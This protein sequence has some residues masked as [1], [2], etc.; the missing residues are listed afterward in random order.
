MLLISILVVSLS[1]SWAQGNTSAYDLNGDYWNILKEEEK[2]ILVL[3][4]IAGIDETKAYI[5]YMFKRYKNA[6]KDMTNCYDML[7][8][9][10][11]MLGHGSVKNT[12]EIIDIVYSDKRNINISLPE[13]ITFARQLYSGV[14]SKDNVNELLNI[15]RKKSNSVQQ[16]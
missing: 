13:V 11:D 12:V 4:Y 14:I 2:K 8:E 3:G 7:I 1:P 9:V 5:G 6:D 16:N 10:D 15:M